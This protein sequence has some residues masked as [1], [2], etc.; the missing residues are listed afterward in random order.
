MKKF[1]VI[2][3]VLS[4]FVW[5][6][7]VWQWRVYHYLA[8]KFTERALLNFLSICFAAVSFLYLA[9]LAVFLKKRGLKI[10]RR[11]IAA[12]AILFL[13][14]ILTRLLEPAEK[15]DA[16]IFLLVGFAI[17][18]AGFRLL[19]KKSFIWQCISLFTIVLVNEIIHYFTLVRAGA[20]GD[21]A[22]GFIACLLGLG[23]S[24]VR[25]PNPVLISPERYFSA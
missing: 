12:V 18:I 14:G 13:F 8:N 23:L 20:V 4:I 19:S 10:L 11:E 25:Y 22:V 3:W 2:S 9:I 24:R 17:G 1:F 7:A 5:S 21:V 15:I 6:G 16:F